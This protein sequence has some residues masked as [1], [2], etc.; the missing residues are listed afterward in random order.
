M[1][2]GLIHAEESRLLRRGLFDVQNEVGLGRGEEAYHQAFLIWLTRAGVPYESK[3]PHHL[4]LGA[5]VA[6]ALVPD[7]AVWDSITVELKS[8]TRRI[9]AEDL[10]QLFDYLK[11]RSDGLGLLANLGLDRVQVERIVWRP[12]ET[13]LQEDWGAWHAKIAGEDRDCGNRVRE[14]LLA[15]YREHGTGYGSKVTCDLVLCALAQQGLDIAVSPI[16]SSFYG[17]VALPAAPLDCIVLDGRVLLVFSGLFENNEYNLRRGMSFLKALGQTW[18]VA[19]NFGKSRLE[20]SGL[21]SSPG[22][23]PRAQTR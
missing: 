15:V 6:S 12:C 3:K 22:A 17:D 1:A 21:H 19:A 18:G 9:R 8:L 14:A 7:L 23:G 10:V 16:A 4:L 2:L 13:S 5:E 20:I 11:C